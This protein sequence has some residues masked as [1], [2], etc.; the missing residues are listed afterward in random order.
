MKNRGRGFDGSP[1]EYRQIRSTFRLF[2]TSHK[3]RLFYF[4]FSQSKMEKV[5]TRSNM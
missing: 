4:R 5:K 2:R 1:A 3:K